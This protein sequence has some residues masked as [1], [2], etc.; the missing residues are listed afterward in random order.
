MNSK[1]RLS[2]PGTPKSGFGMLNRIA[3]SYSQDPS[4]SSL[5]RPAFEFRCAFLP[6]PTP[7]ARASANTSRNLRTDISSE[8]SIAQETT[9]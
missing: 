4:L 7:G 5:T 6:P 3:R 1:R 8:Q 2:N 9:Q